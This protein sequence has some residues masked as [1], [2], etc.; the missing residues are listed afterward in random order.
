MFKGHLNYADLIKRPAIKTPHQNKST[1]PYR[2]E[3]GVLN[4]N[5]HLLQPLVKYASCCHCLIGL[6]AADLPSVAIH[7]SRGRNRTVPTAEPLFAFIPCRVYSRRVITLFFRKR[8]GF[9]FFFTKTNSALW[10]LRLRTSAAE[11]RGNSCDGI[12]CSDSAPSLPVE[13]QT[14]D[15]SDAFKILSAVF[16]F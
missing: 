2:D 8:R 11:S 9:F 1:R 7:S 12:R 3:V 4:V 10:P 15:L 16:I 5:V 13:P 14:Q 6:T